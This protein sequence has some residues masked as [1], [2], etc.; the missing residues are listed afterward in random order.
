MTV[1]LLNSALMPA[2]GDYRLRR[3]SAE[4]WA[5]EAG[6][7]IRAGTARSSIGYPDTARVLSALC[8]VEVPVSWDLTVPE[9]SDVLLIARL[10]YRV[11]DPRTK[12]AEDFHFFRA[13][14]R[15]AKGE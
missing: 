5:A 9:D 8:G 7:A 2:E 1:H 15:A 3:I 6:E 12:G 4:A 13:E 14:Y 11:A 10:P